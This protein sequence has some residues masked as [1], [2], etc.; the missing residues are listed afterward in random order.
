MSQDFDAAVIGSGPNGLCAAIALARA[1]LRVVLYEAHDTVGGGMRSAELTLPG[2]RHDVCSAI[3]PMALSSPFLREL[4]LEQHGLEWVHPE[5]PMAHPLEAEGVVVS[6]E[7]SLEATQE[8]LGTSGGGYARRYGPFVSGWERLAADALGPLGVPGDPILLG[9]FGLHAFQS[10]MGHARRAFFGEA[11]AAYFAG[12]AAHSVLPL[13]RVPSAAIGLMLMLAGHAVGWPFPRGGAQSLADALRACLEAHGGVVRTG[14]PITELGQVETQGPTF[15]DTGP[16]ALAAIAG[17]A[18]PESYGRAVQRFRYGPG[19]FK[20]DYALDGPIPWTDARVARAATVHLG[21]STAEICESERLAWRGEH[22][23]RPYCILA[24]HSLFDETRAPEGKHTC[25]VYCH[26]PHGSTVDRQ[27]AIEDQIE[28]WAPGFRERVLESRV[29]TS[30]DLE[31]Y[32]PNYVGGDVNGGA[33]VLTQLFTRPRV[34]LNPYATP[35]PRLFLCS[36]STP[37][38]GGVHGMG[39]YHAVRLSGAVPPE[40]ASP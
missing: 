27:A 11:G 22:A 2:F 32:N 21:G 10:G 4:D 18:L 19:A 8:G 28:R 15:F 35:S 26:V 13:E 34:Q 6:L 5:V 14:T 39:G 3:H 24:Q 40:S 17:P 33:A 36:A 16:R 25:W 1:G 30:A 20:V 31:A 38:G 12:L 9:R 37:P 29:T 7:R 23:E